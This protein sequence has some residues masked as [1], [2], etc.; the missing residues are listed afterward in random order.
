M[1]RTASGVFGA[2]RGLRVQVRTSE[3]VKVYESVTSKDV[4]LSLSAAAV[5]SV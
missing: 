3:T 4:D 1:C 2:G 5:P